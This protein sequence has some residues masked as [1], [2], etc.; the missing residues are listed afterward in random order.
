MAAA[1]AARQC[2][3][4]GNARGTAKA[5][6]RLGNARAPARQCPGTAKPGH[7]HGKP[8]APA[9]QCPGTGSAKPRHGKAPARQSPGTGTAMPAAPAIP[10]VQQSPRHRRC[11]RVP[12]VARRRREGGKDGG[13]DGREEGRDMRGRGKRETE[14]G[15]CSTRRLRGDTESQNLRILG[16]G[17]DLCTV[18]VSK[19]LPRQ[20]HLEQVTQER[21]QV[22]LECLQRGKLHT[23]PRQLFRSS[24]T[25][26]GQKFFLMVR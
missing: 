23:L 16:A 20:G 5:G 4:T 13:R 26:H 22:G 11:R 12:G 21:I 18:Q 2:P 15:R 8:R 19:P 6:H 9:R 1:A 3:D 25:R 10:A 17:R 7:R 24:A 14:G